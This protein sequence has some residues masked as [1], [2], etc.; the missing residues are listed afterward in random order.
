MYIH[1][2]DVQFLEM[3]LL[4]SFFHVYAYALILLC[5]CL[6]NYYALCGIFNFL[7]CHVVIIAR[8]EMVELFLFIYLMCVLLLVTLILQCLI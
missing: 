7:N 8:L 2:S 1:K 5:T 4:V 6:D 3:F